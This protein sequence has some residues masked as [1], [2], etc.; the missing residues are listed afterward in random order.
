MDGTCLELAGKASEQPSRVSEVD[1]LTLIR[2][3]QEGDRAAF[4]ALV[5]LYDRNVL[6]LALQVVG[7]PEEARDL[8]QEAFLKVYRSLRHFRLEARFSTWLYRVVM[9]VCLD[10]LRR[11][12]TRKEVAAPPAND[13]E[14]EYFQ[15]VPDERPTLD[16]ERA[17]HSK[18]IAHRIQA[19]L[20]RLNPRERMVFELKHYQGLKLR[21]IGE[22]CKT[23]EQTVKNCLFRATQKL[24]TEL[25]DLV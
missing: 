14:P 9:N 7:S 12:N 4:E 13:G 3:A 18:E 16:P 6:R 5:R 2:R 25:G 17:T 20:G 21:V 8:Y 11:R 1:E 24:R 19:A 10:Y 22:M 23:S 15:T